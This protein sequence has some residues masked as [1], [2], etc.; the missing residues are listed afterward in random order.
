MRPKINSGRR[1]RAD[2]QVQ[3]IGGAGKPLSKAKAGE[4]WRASNWE[5]SFF[6]SSV[7]ASCWLNGWSCCMYAL[8][9]IIFRG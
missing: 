6:F 3:V 1:E 9:E 2:K 8:A 7:G 5:K 4:F